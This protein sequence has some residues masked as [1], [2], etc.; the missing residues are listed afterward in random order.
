MEKGCEMIAERDRNKI[1]ELC[2]EYG[3]SRAL[4]FGSSTSDA[5]VSRDIDLGVS[6]VPVGRFFEFYGELLFSL[7]RPV[8]LVDLDV[9]SAFTSIIQA[10]GLLMYG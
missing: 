2:R 10:E 9:K 6:G 4:L 7:T 5:A 8:D 3:V 1:I